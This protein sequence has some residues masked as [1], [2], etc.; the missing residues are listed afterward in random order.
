MQLYRVGTIVLTVKKNNCKTP[1]PEAVSRFILRKNQFIESNYKSI[2][3]TPNKKH[4]VQSNLLSNHI[5]VRLIIVRSPTELK[6]KSRKQ[7][8]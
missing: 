3:E 6:D 1:L 2:R 7:L 8:M 5:E 4:L